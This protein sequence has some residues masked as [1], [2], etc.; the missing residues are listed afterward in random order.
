MF[1]ERDDSQ[2]LRREHFVVLFALPHC[3]IVSYLFADKPYYFAVPPN[4]ERQAQTS[5]FVND[6]LDRLFECDFGPFL[7][8]QS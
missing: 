7:Q 4:V 1:I 2:K 6:F 8:R 3:R 5:V